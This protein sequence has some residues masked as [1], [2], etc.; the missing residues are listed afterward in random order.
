VDKKGRRLS[1]IELMKMN[2]NK[3]EKAE[4]SDSDEEKVRMS[5]HAH[6]V[7]LKI[8]FPCLIAEW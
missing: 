2:L 3:V 5:V 8:F 6:L 7:M 1:Q 4:G